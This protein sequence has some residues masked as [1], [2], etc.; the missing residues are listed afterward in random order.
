MSE[1]LT[2]DYKN[3][4]I[5]WAKLGP[6]WWPA[7]VKDPENLP[8]EVLDFKKPPLL[9]VQFFDEDS[10][11]YIKTWANVHPYNCE[12]KNDFIKKG[13][14]AFRAKAP[15]MEKFPKDVTNAEVKI[16]GDPNILS[17]PMFIPEKKRNYVAEIFGTPSPKGKSHKDKKRNNNKNK[18]DTSHITHRRFIGL[19]DYKAYI[20]IQYPGKDRIPGDFEDDEVIRI[21]RETEQEFKCYLCRF[22][23]K[24]LEVMI[25]HTK[26]HIYGTYVPP[27]PKKYKKTATGRPNKKLQKQK[28]LIE[29]TAYG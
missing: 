3:G 22:T 5:V 14:A 21:N 4:D 17:D 8:E 20:C 25:L 15:H 12:K 9:I 27:G 24:R 7:E 19:D 2:T 16:G 23:T 18:K 11:E 13:M 28:R 26:S 1:E 10:Y 29:Q 6:S